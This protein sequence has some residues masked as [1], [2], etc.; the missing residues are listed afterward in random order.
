MKPGALG[1]EGQAG[2]S[3]PGAIFL[4]GVIGIPPPWVQLPPLLTGAGSA[5]WVVVPGGREVSGSQDPWG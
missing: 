4:G 3:S 5:A 1:P 2:C